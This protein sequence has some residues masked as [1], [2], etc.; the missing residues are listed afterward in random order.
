MRVILK[1]YLRV[2]SLAFQ[3]YF[4]FENFFAVVKFKLDPT[5]VLSR[6]S[7][8]QFIFVITSE[9]GQPKGFTFLIGTPKPRNV[10]N[11]SQWSVSHTLRS[12]V[13]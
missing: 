13:Q 12:S 2:G 1:I 10:P 8:I 4:I 7:G 3:T 9:K 6:S 5:G 11:A